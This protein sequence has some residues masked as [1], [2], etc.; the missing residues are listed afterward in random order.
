MARDPNGPIPGFEDEFTGTIGHE[1]R[2][3]RTHFAGVDRKFRSEAEG[4]LDW[5]E[6]KLG[7][8]KLI[9]IKKDK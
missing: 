4:D 1:K 6:T 8:F 5:V 3:H 9:R 7:V 2:I